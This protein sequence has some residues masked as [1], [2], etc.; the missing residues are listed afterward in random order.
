MNIHA[1]KLELMRLILETNNPGMISSIKKILKK[2]TKGDFWDTLTQ[3][4]KDEI[5]QGIEE[6]DRGEVIDY[7]S[8]MKRHR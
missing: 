3:S 4:Q 2:E 1:E 5:L 7:E 6:I 8:L